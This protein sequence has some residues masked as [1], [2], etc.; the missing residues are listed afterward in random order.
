MLVQQDPA[1]A[2][3]VRPGTLSG[4]LSGFLFPLLLPRALPWA[5]IALRLRREEADPCK[6][7][8]GNLLTAPV[9]MTLGPP[10]ES[11]EALVLSAIAPGVL[12]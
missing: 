7:D 4:N 2:L 3:V 11:R 1:P 5:V 9:K 12:P 8:D 10:R 6:G